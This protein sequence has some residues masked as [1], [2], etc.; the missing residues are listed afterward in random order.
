MLSRVA[1]S[2]YWMARYI[3]RAEST[4]RLIDVNLQMSLDSPITFSDQ[5]QPLIAI[6][7]DTEAFEERYK[8]PNRDNVIQFLALDNSNPNSVLSCLSKARENAR[9]IR[10]V[11]SSE[12][13]EQVN[14]FYLMVSHRAA[15]RRA[16]ESS[17]T[18]FSDVKL[19][20][21]I[22]AGV[23]D[24]TTSHGEAWH[25]M[26]M[27]RLLE[28]SDNTT[29]LLDVKYFLLLP[30]VEDVGGAVDDMQWAILLRSAT[31]F[32]MYRKK[33]GPILPENVVEFLLLDQEFPR[34]ILFCLMHAETSLHA[35]SGTMP[36]TYR[37]VVDRRLGVLR[38]ELAYAQVS[39]IIT[40]GL[41]EF[42]DGLQTKLNN[43]GDAITQTFFALQPV[44]NGA[45]AN[46]GGPV[47][48]VLSSNQSQGGTRGDRRL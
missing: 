29:R 18:F 4:A 5:W 13:W 6:T 25:F 30:S 20:A 46:S 24:N 39:D 16:Q 31:A 21:H 12:T 43:V 27:G 32:E 44:G 10:E 22:V 41:H 33:Y 47:L 3:E 19:N 2:L 17:S 15:L 23:A 37:N 36:G 28:R 45:A 7:G 34:A 8:T 11:I 48:D 9:S 38:S 42:L 1:E 14:R 40:T 35:I 26:Q